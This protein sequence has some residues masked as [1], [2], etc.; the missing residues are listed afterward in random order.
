MW[1][2][3]VSHNP[4]SVLPPMAFYG[5]ERALW[6]LH[7]PKNQLTGIPSDSISIL[8]KLSVLDLAGTHVRVSSPFIWPNARIIV[9]AFVDR[10]I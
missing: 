2:L 1:G 3:E 9:R 5:L 6:E 8:K 7:L 10:W 4:I